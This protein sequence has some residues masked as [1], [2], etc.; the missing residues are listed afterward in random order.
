MNKL[1][2]PE[3]GQKITMENRMLIVPDHPIIPFIE[4]DGIGQD[5]WAA[6]VRVLDAAVKKAY[7]DKKKIHW[8]EVYAGEKANEVYGTDTWLPQETLDCINIPNRKRL[9]SE[10]FRHIKAKELIVT[11]HPVV[12]SGDA[13]KDIMNIPK[14]ISLWLKENFINKKTTSG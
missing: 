7:G 12:T 10:K 8:M 6:A 11:D 3:A 4:G 9:S 2:I 1:R 5:I 14:W 13:T